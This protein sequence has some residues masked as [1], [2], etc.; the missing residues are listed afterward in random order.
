MIGKNKSHLF[1]K[2]DLLHYKD[3]KIRFRFLNYAIDFIIKIENLFIN[4]F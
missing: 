3:K 4:Y 2:I 1:Y